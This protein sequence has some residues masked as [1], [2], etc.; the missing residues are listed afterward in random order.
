MDEPACPAV[1]RRMTPVM[2]NTPGEMAPI[3]FPTA[4][5]WSTGDSR[6]NVAAVLAKSVIHGVIA[7]ERGRIADRRRRTRLQ[8]GCFQK[9]CR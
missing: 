3:S 5:W 2:G 9:N 1:A 7:D 8:P 6:V 4:R